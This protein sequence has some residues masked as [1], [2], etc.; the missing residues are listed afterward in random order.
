MRVPLG[1]VSPVLN[2]KARPLYYSSPP[3]ASLILGFASK[4][5]HPALLYAVG[6]RYICDSF[7]RFVPTKSGYLERSPREIRRYLISLYLLSNSSIAIVSDRFLTSSYRK[8]SPLLTI[9][10]DLSSNYEDATIF[11]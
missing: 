9:L 2:P 5:L 3:S 1:L 7:S 10:L 11:D 6:A 8:E 4:D